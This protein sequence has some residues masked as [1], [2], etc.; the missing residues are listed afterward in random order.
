M[1]AV[2]IEL[3]RITLLRVRM[4]I[5]INVRMQEKY[6]ICFALTHFMCINDV[7]LAWDWF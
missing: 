5:R 4:R 1:K 3:I 6:R 7:D 2:V